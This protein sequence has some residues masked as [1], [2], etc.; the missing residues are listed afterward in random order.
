MANTKSAEK[1]ARQAVRNRER[2]R[3]HV[4]KM[5]TAVKRVRAAVATGDK[6]QAENQ[7]AAQPGLSLSGAALEILAAVVTDHGDQ[8]I[9]RRN[10]RH[11]R[12]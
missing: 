11:D 8:A 12:E 6:A 9:L 4:S 5:R 7:L 1:K 3:V 2:N 10:L